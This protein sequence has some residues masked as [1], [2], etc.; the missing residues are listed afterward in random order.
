MRS[1]ALLDGCGVSKPRR[2]RFGST[3]SANL[4][5]EGSDDVDPSCHGA[6]Q[7]FWALIVRFVPFR[8]VFLPFALAGSDWLAAVRSVRAVGAVWATCRPVGA[9]GPALP[10]HDTMGIVGRDGSDPPPATVS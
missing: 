8:A 2:P 4:L 10:P 7:R 5:A 6:G 1:I 9:G 3:D